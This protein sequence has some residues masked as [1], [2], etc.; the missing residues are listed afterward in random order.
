[1][2]ADLTTNHHFVNFPEEVFYEIGSHLDLKDLRS[3]NQTDR[4]IKLSVA[5]L[6]PF[7]I[8]EHLENLAETFLHIKYEIPKNFEKFYACK[9]KAANFQNGSFDRSQALRDAICS[10]FENV[11]LNNVNIVLRT[12][13]FSE[14]KLLTTEMIK[15]S[16]IDSPI[17]WR[18]N[19]KDNRIF[20]LI[21]DLLKKNQL[22]LKRFEYQ[23][24]NTSLDE[25]I[26]KWMVSAINENRSIISI[27]LGVKNWIPDHLNKLLKAVKQ[28]KQ[29]SQVNISEFDDSNAIVLKNIG[30]IIYNKLN[31]SWEVRHDGKNY[32]SYVR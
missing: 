11:W 18:D 21:L 31:G 15:N 7:K 12:Y 17:L 14:D 1:M 22:D 5:S 16:K 26:L 9:T 10:L 23:N 32:W 3:F 25:N 19:P 30:N 6:L 8:Q 27:D 13:P 24:Y 4:K 2:L 20:I 29:I 28:N